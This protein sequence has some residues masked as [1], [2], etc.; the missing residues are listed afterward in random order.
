MKNFIFLVALVALLL[1]GCSLAS[2][3]VVGIAEN[4]TVALYRNLSVEFYGP[5]KEAAA[6]VFNKDEGLVL[7]GNALVGRT[8]FKESSGTRV[9]AVTSVQTLKIQLTQAQYNEAACEVAGITWEAHEKLIAEGRTITVT[10]DMVRIWAREQIGFSELPS[11]IQKFFG[12]K[13]FSAYDNTSVK[14]FPNVELPKEQ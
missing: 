9:P 6:I 11:E 2:D 4:T 3:L 5:A 10:V 14:F 12:K 1:P 8:H 7:L 13:T